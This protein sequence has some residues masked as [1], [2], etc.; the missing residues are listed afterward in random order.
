MIVK[1]RLEVIKLQKNLINLLEAKLLAVH[2]VTQDNCGKKT[3]DVDGVSFLAPTKRLSLA[4]T[5]KIDGRFD[6][7]KDA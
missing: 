4:Y 6:P 7:I 5:P 3:A 1:K 2:K